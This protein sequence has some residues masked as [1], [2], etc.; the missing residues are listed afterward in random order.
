[1][2]WIRTRDAVPTIK[3]IRDWAEDIKTDAANKARK[4]IA[5]GKDPDEV[6]SQMA[7]TLTNKLIHN[8]S[9]RLREAGFQ[10]EED[11]IEAARLLFDLDKKSGNPE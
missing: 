1:M 6:I 2:G 5:Q 10:Q 3:G 8:P 4:Q 9:S 7:H 11:L